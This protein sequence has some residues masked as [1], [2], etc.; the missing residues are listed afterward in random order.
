MSFPACGSDEM[1]VKKMY[2]F[3][4]NPEKKV[5]RNMIFFSMFHITKVVEEFGDEIEK[6]EK[7][8][9]KYKLCDKYCRLFHK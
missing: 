8:L 4:C 5:R 1:E 3:S 2:C 7:T 9:K 6:R